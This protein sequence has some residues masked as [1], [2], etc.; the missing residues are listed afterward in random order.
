MIVG[1][2]WRR[3]IFIVRRERFREELEEEMRLHQEL[4]TKANINS[5][6]TRSAAAAASRRA[7]GNTGIAQSASQDAWGTRWM[8]SLEMDLRYASRTLRNN[9]WFTIVAVLTLGVGIASTT[10][11]FTVVNGVLLRKLPVRD[12]D[13]VVVMW[14][15]DRS[16][17]VTHFPVSYGVFTALRAQRGAFE[18]VAGVDFN[19]AWRM[20]VEIGDAA[21]ILHGGIVA[22]DFFGVL[23]VMPLLGRTLTADDDVVGGPHVLVIS[24]RLWRSTLGGDQ[25]VLGRTIRLGG[26]AYS[27]VGVIPQEFAYPRGADFWTTLAMV[28][29]DWEIHP[30][31]V[32]LDLVGRLRTGATSPEALTEVNRVVRQLEPDQPNARAVLH[33]L[34]DVIVGD[35][36]PA[37]IILFAA[38]LLVLVLASVN[39]GG[40][41]LVRGEARMREFAVRSALG[42]ERARVVRQLVTESLALAIIGGIV[43]ALLAAGALRVFAAIAPPDLQRVGELRIDASVL[44][45]TLGTSVIAAVV[46]GLAPARGAAG[47]DLSQVLRVGTQPVAESHWRRFAVIGQ[48]ALAVLIVAGAGLLTRSLF[49]LSRAEMGFSADGL[50]FVQPALPPGRYPDADKVRQIVNRFVER[51]RALPG[52]TGITAVSHLP[53]SLNGGIDIS[54]AAQDQD[55]QA[56]AANPLLSYVPTRPDLFRVLGLP[57]LRGRGFTD[58]DRGGSPLVV[59]VSQAIALRTWP[60][61]DPIGKRLRLGGPRSHDPWRTVVGVVADARYRDLEEVRGSIYVPDAQDVIQTPAILAVRYAP[62]A[63]GLVSSVRKAMKEVDSDVKVPFVASMDDLLDAQLVRPRFNTTLLDALATI[64]LVLA[65]TGLYA[66]MSTRVA[67]R[68]REIGIRMALGA[69]APTVAREVAWQGM[70]LALAGVA[71]GLLVTFFAARL[72]TSLL[73]GL[74]PA[75]PLTLSLTILLLLLAAAIA[76]YLPARRA[77]RVDPMEALRYE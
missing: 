19:G 68:T 45:F 24:S 46:C 35:V 25:H 70:K 7:F 69:D 63:T 10:A 50:L 64:A 66:V 11:M 30:T 57:V 52:V 59:V 47:A 20:P 36:R 29:P 14:T 51:L 61:Q 41:L 48:V 56:A 23:G 16:S 55:D 71:T 32:T 62:R 60:S 33:S 54:Y 42:A 2:V 77:T 76:T 40:L 6:M 58:A 49:L 72:L 18:G 44:L 75:D 3:V 26:V 34:S 28:V 39:V 65:I 4:R 5:G 27:I 9:P 15:E 12:Q 67:Q 43:G 73:F 1:E 53:F 22:G 13:R 38:A 17:Q 74:S 37:V 8:E 21:T 31:Q